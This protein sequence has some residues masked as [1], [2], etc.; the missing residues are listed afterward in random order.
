MNVI[1]YVKNDVIVH[2]VVILYNRIWK[3]EVRREKD[4]L[5]TAEL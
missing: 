2:P 5:F 3:K 1:V 4:R